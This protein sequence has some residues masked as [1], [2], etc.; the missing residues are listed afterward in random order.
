MAARTS[1]RAFRLVKRSL[2]IG[3]PLSDPL[4]TEKIVGYPM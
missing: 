4:S 3:V 1:Q 2:V